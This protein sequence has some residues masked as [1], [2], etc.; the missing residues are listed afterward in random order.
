MISTGDL[1]LVGLCFLIGFLNDIYGPQPYHYKN[2]IVIVDRKYQ[3]PVYCDVNHNHHVYF[4]TDT[5]RMKI[6]KK[7]LGKKL[8]QKKSRRK[9]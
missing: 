9:K 6:D 2:K 3:C 8:K 4:K 5:F 7:L 1:A